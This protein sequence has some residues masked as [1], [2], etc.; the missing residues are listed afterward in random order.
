MSDV[1][2]RK[3]MVRTVPSYLKALG[4]GVK[5][6]YTIESERE[7]WRAVEWIATDGRCVLTEPRV[8]NTESSGNTPIPMAP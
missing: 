3:A 7:R 6:G 1:R 8:Q 2:R 5:C 4:C